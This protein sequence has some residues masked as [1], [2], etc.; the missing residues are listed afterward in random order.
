[1]YLHSSVLSANWYNLLTFMMSAA[2]MALWF[3]SSI[4]GFDL[5]S[6]VTKFSDLAKA[7]LPYCMIEW[8]SVFLHYSFLEPCQLKDFF[9]YNIFSLCYCFY[10]KGHAF[11]SMFEAF[12]FDEEIQ[13]SGHSNMYN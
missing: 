1:M 4:F 11:S 3:P 2:D 5:A 13:K 6:M 7:C 12:A 10:D 9:Y 8:R